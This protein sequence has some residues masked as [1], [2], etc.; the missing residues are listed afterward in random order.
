MKTI[1]FGDDLESWTFV[2][3]KNPQ[4]KVIAGNLINENKE[5]SLVMPPKGDWLVFETNAEIPQGIHLFD[6]R[7]GK[8]K[9]GERLYFMG[10][11]YGSTHPVKVEGSFKG[12]T[13]AENLS[14]DVPKGT[15]NGCS[16]G[17]VFDDQGQLVGLVSLGYIDH[18]TD[19]MVFEPASTDY[20]KKI[21][22]SNLSIK[23]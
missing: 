7:T 16:G 18:K 14:L 15:Y 2:S 4:L 21:I 3:K 19:T 13:E 12:Y 10:Y 20:F 6:M 23:Q 22:K 1:S 5:E 17:P 11:P 9:V 8:M